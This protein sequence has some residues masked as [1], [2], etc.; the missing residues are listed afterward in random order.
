MAEFSKIY[1]AWR[2]GK[3]S[4]R[5]IVGILERQADNNVS[6][7][8]LPETRNLVKTEGFIPY[9]EFPDLEKT[10]EHN[11]I[12]IFSHR[13]IKPERP[14]V[15][16]FYDFW[17]VDSALAEDKFYLLG[18]TQGLTAADNFE[19]LADYNYFPG[20]R[21]LTDLSGLT[22]LQLPKD[23]LK[24]GDI[25]QYKLE[26]ENSYDPYAVEVFSQGQKVGY[27]KKIHCRLFHHAPQTALRVVVKA[28]EKN[29]TIRKVFVTVQ[30]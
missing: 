9:F 20:I 16:T 6:F 23:S 3:G 25:L 28:I 26:K 17:E 19:F 22:H 15:L 11:V 30:G 12:Q 27:I 8:Y 14:D 7:K 1:L 18:K 21:F 5:H 2:K 13:L 10:Y 29:G 4:R 24:K